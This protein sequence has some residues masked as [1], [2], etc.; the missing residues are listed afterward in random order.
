MDCREGSS[1]E[2]SR[3]KR[4]GIV[5]AEKYGTDLRVI[6]GAQEKRLSGSNLHERRYQ[7]HR[8]QVDAHR[9]LLCIG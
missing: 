6:P 9:G 5:Y 1:P 3:P 4:R 2:Q 7:V 8:G